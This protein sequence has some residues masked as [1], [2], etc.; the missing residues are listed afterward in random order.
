MMHNTPYI[1]N[2]MKKH[3]SIESRT[4]GEGRDDKY[5]RFDDNDVVVALRFLDFM[6]HVVDSQRNKQNH[7]SHT[8]TC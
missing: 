8:T 7:I 3:R 1:Y 5:R 2:S 4:R 6:V